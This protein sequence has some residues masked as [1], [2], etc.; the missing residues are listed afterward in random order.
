MDFIDGRDLLA[1]F[2]PIATIVQSADVDHLFQLV[3]LLSEFQIGLKL[4][5]F[6]VGFFA[7]SHNRHPIVSLELEDH[8]LF[9]KT[10]FSILKL[11]GLIK[12]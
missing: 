5:C 8:V 10:H 9:V 7:I 2:L 3:H 11:I 1:Q 6:L 12:G 4:G